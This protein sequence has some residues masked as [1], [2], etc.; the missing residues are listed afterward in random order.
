MK[1]L[2]LFFGGAVFLSLSA[3]VTK[4][5]VMRKIRVTQPRF[6]IPSNGPPINKLDGHNSL[7]AV[8]AL[9]LATL[10]V[11]GF[12]IMSTGGLS[13]AFD[14]SSVA[15]LRGMAR[16]TLGADGSKTD[17]EA[18]KEVEEWVAKVLFKKDGKDKGEQK[19][20]TEVE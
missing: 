17:E 1:Q 6:F 15:E 18:E 19:P 20:D 8:E 13:W 12:G 14:V 16:K 5:A 10:N 9:G 7:I 11:F 3:L 2:G 4:R